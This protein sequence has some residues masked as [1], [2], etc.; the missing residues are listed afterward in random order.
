MSVHLFY[1]SLIFK[2]IVLAPAMPLFRFDKQR[3]ANK[4]IGK[5]TS[6]QIDQIHWLLPPICK[7]N[8]CQMLEEHL[9]DIFQ[10]PR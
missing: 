4:R 10:C 1:V 7:L 6:R 5:Y 2:D 8:E 3:H 9:V